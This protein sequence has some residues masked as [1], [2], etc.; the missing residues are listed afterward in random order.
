MELSQKDI[1]NTDT[2]IIGGIPDFSELL[3]YIRSIYSD[4]N[5]NFTFRTTKTT[6]RFSKAIESGILNF[7]NESHK[8]LFID[9]LHNGAFSLNDEYL[10][11][12]WQMVY[13]NKLFRQITEEV[14]M[15]AIYQGRVSLSANDI[16]CYLRYLKTDNNSLD[17]SESTLKTTS[18]KY[19]T[20]LKKLNLAEGTIRKIILHP[21]ISNDLFV[22]FI[23]WALLVCPTD[24]TLNNP[25]IQFGFLDHSTL[26][27]RLKK[28][29]NISYWSITQ[30]GNDI[31]IELS[32]HE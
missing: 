14:F 4:E 19:L 12:F 11:L 2:N 1:Y 3:D 25:F 32:N 26:I 6:N 5:D 30:I 21:T 22:Y 27:A 18:S 23:R 9:A 8:Q 28:I 17:W 7:A 20:I 15:K 31:T 13:S 24:K 29:E 10:L 16:L